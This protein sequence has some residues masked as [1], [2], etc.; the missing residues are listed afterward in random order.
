[1]RECMFAQIKV[2]ANG[3]VSWGCAT[4]IHRIRIGGEEWHDDLRARRRALCEEG[5]LKRPTLAQPLQE[6]M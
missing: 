2:I 1:M 5:G 4:R 6:T 3:L